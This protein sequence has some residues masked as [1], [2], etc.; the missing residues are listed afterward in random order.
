MSKFF[1]LKT[2]SSRR[3]GGFTMMETVVAIFVIVTI[4]G[5]MLINYRSG[6][7]TNDLKR[8]ISKTALDL[9]RAQNAA[10]NT[11]LFGASAPFGYGIYYSTN[12]PTQALLFADL[13]DNKSYDVAGG[14]LVETIN[15]YSG[16]RI[17]ALSPSSPLV[18]FFR[19]PEPRTFINGLSSGTATIT[20]QLISNT[21][22]TRRV[23]VNASGQINIEN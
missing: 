14:E 17:S 12:N 8:A 10:L 3:E 23:I 4:S 6:G 1:K 7:A 20:L 5:I 19:A 9:S 21:A 22:E 11:T 2:P 15:L 16:V 13:N 18:V